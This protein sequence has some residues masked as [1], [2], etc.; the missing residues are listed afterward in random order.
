MGNFFPRWT[1]W[2]PL[3]LA[4]ALCFILV[5]VTLGVTYYFTPKYTRVGY[6][7]T[8]PVP[9]SH[10]IHAGQL[11]LDCRYCHSFVEASGHSNVPTN[12]TCFNCHGVGKGNIRS[13]SPKLEKVMQAEASGQPIPWVKVHKLPDYA[14][15]NHSVHVNRGVSCVSCHG[16]I[17]EMEVVRHDQPLSMGWCLD[18]H[19]NPE[20]NLRPLEQ[21]TNLNY[22]AGQLDRAAFYKSLL[23][24]GV[25]PAEIAA[26]IPGGRSLDQVPADVKGLVELAEKAYGGQVAQKEVGLQ[27]KKHWQIQPP[28]SCA[29]CHR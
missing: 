2:L 8:Q 29:A 1:N 12:Q 3:K 26:E 17:N 6:E 21:I 16:K 18:C 14:Y 27:L 9:F 11:G 5:G 24:K 23:D 19:R 4:I 13:N 25:K 7:P 20:L 15:F 28:E 10:K 22:N